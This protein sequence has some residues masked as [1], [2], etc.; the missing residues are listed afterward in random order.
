[1]S[2]RKPK[3]KPDTDESFD[4][5][6]HEEHMLIAACLNQPDIIENLKVGLFGDE[7]A[8]AIFQWMLDRKANRIP[9]WGWDAGVSALWRF[10]SGL[11]SEVTQWLNQLHSPANWPYWEEVCR[12][13]AT[14]RH[15][16]DAARSLIEAAKAGEVNLGDVTRQLQAIEAASKTRKPPTMGD[17]VAEAF[18]DMEARY[19]SEKPFLGISTG[20]GQLDIMTDAL[21]PGSLWVVAA[22]PS[23]GKTTFACNVVID[24]AVTNKTPAV[25]FSLEM[26]SSSIVQKLCHIIGGVSQSACK[27]RQLPQSEGVKLTDAGQKLIGSSLT[28]VDNATTLEA[29]AVDVR[30]MKEKHGVRVVVVD[31][32]QKVGLE[33]SKGERWDDI[34]RVSNALKNLAMEHDITVLAL[35]QLN[36]E[37]EKEDR[38]P[39]LSDLRG[40]AEIEADA[41]VIAFLW[42]NK[43][44]VKMKVGKSRMG[45][46]GPVPI[47]VDYDTGRFTEVKERP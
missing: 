28:I 26:K 16:A 20:I 9:N 41:D 6:H 22:R 12:E 35:A 40:S 17:C 27:R 11:A 3:A 1:M 21:T 23:V 19:D 47:A 10:D 32:L 42:R 13:K 31:Y 4:K 14:L 34:G 43:D 37:M 8:K 5:D 2:T 44:G 36:R 24:V 38:E 39:N 45:T 7:R 30:R 33:H 15:S 29:I 46:T 25:L 18:A